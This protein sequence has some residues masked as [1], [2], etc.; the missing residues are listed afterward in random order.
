MELVFCALGAFLVEALLIVL[1]IAP[2]WTLRT[3][4]ARSAP[5]PDAG[6]GPP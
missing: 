2:R 3:W 4:G 6:T 5:S 1:V